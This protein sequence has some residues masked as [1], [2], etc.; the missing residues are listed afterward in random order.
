M[1]IGGVLDNQGQ[2]LAAEFGPAA[3][4]VR[5]D[6]T[7]EAD[8]AS[9]VEAA[10]NIGSLHGMVNHAGIGFAGACAARFPWKA[11]PA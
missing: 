5:V 8:Y 3:A 11:W 4:F 2:A 10:Q 9:A 7:S 6:A 1:V